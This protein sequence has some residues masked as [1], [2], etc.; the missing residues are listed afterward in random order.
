MLR[1]LIVDDEVEVR[2]RIGQLLEEGCIR[3][4]R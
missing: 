4:C 2:R 1:V 3:T